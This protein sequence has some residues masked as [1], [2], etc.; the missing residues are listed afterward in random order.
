[1]TDQ[2]AKKLNGDVV[3]KAGNLSNINDASG[4][5]SATDLEAALTAAGSDTLYIA[6][7]TYIDTDL[8]ADNILTNPTDGS[9]VVG[10]SK[11]GVILKATATRTVLT[12]DKAWTLKTLTIQNTSVDQDAIYANSGSTFN[13][14]DVVFDGFY[15][16]AIYGGG[17]HERLELKNQSGLS[18]GFM[19]QGE[20]TFNY[21]TVR[22]SDRGIGCYGT[23]TITLNNPIFLGCRSQMVRTV[24]DTPVVVINNPVV[25]AMGYDGVAGYAFEASVGTVTVNTPFVLPNWNDN[26]ATISPDC[27]VNGTN[28]TSPPKFVTP[29]Y[30]GWG[31]LGIDDSD[32]FD[33]WKSITDYANQFGLKT[34]FALHNAHNFTDWA[35]LAPY[36]AYGNEIRCH[37]RGANPITATV[38]FSVSAPSATNPTL[39]IVA[40][41]SDVDPDN[42]SASLILSEDGVEIL[43]TDI[44]TSTIAQVKTAVEGAG[45]TIDSE[46]GVEYDG[47]DYGAWLAAQS[48]LTI[49]TSTG[50]PTEITY[51]RERYLYVRI[52]VQ[53]A[54]IETGLR[55]QGLSTYSVCTFTLPSGKG[56][57]ED[58]AWLMTQSNFTEGGTNAFKVVSSGSNITDPSVN[59]DISNL[60]LSKIGLLSAPYTWQGT[61]IEANVVSLVETTRYYGYFIVI[62]DHGEDKFSLDNWKLV[63]DAC[64]ACG[65]D[66]KT[67]ED[68]YDEVTGSGLWTNTSGTIWT[69]DLTDNESWEI[70]KESPLNMAGTN[71][72]TFENDYY[73]NQLYFTQSIGL[74]DPQGA[75]LVVYDDDYTPTDEDVRDGA[76]VNIK[77]G[78]NIDMSGLSEDAGTIKVKLSGYIKSFTGK[79]GVTAY[80]WANS[81]GGLFMNAPL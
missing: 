27:T 37:A 79:D 43:N 1:M 13:T 2:I 57:D 61:D 52:V 12:N 14:E 19:T 9:T 26:D 69:R 73:G 50:S 16:A 80:K 39:S 38:A 64:V 53:K 36:V 34:S 33:H 42:W 67:F 75:H 18:N 76:F 78:G 48:D 31:Y 15:K 81:G 65:W 29:R 55:N 21:L 72:S 77:G 23:D 4:W 49:S 35:E 24:Q 3:Y 63:V 60:D 7:G 20:T 5:S 28:I 74:H 6:N 11:A 47:A 66:I 41:Q 56:S 10:E 54:M 71:I 68:V 17:T 58:R 45:W 32:N 25:V 40:D 62:N 44:S 46:D 70:Y 22:D 51:E 59:A 8:D 30:P